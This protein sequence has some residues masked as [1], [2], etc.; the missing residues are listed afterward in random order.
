M[1]RTQA[2][3]LETAGCPHRAVL[4]SRE[5]RLHGNRCPGRGQPGTSADSGNYSDGTFAFSRFQVSRGEERNL[6]GHLR[7]I[8]LEQKWGQLGRDLSRTGS[9]NGDVDKFKTT[10]L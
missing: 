4:R 9:R 2:W 8:S 10:G 3:L 5:S 7:D 6:N 1:P